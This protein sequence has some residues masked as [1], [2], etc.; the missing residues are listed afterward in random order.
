MSRRIAVVT[1]H[2]INTSGSQY[3]E[4]FKQNLL[5][6][7]PRQDRGRL[8]FREVVW[9][10]IVRGR[11]DDYM[12]RASAD[13]MK[14]SR[15]R[16]LVVRALGDAACYQKSARRQNSAYYDIQQRLLD[17]LMDLEDLSSDADQP[18]LVIVAHSLGCHIASSFAWDV[19]R[20][21]HLSD[22]QL[23][24][25]PDD[26]IRHLAKVVRAGSAIRRLDTFSSFVTLGSNMPLFTF[27]FGPDRVF[28]ITSTSV[29]GWKAAFP[30]RLLQ[31]HIR[32]KAKW[33]NIYSPSDPLGFPLKC[34]NPAYRDEPR[35]RDKAVAVEGFGWPFTRFYR[36]HVN[37]WKNR[38]VAREVARI[39]QDLMHAAG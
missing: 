20:I 25:E 23:D 10:D 36:A 18:L 6:A 19:N 34:L 29:P 24:R 32:E 14:A 22:D 39:L 5:A 12:N 17:Q 8:L 4:P 26:G 21:K 30:G 38:E 35:I 9:A 16:D 11:Q 31:D 1:I 15:L 2:G 27:T 37:Y 33:L 7:L 28:P 3:S 13:G